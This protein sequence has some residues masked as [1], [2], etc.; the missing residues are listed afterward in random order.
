MVDFAAFENFKL[1]RDE[2]NALVVLQ[3]MK[4]DFILKRSSKDK[5]VKMEMT[6]WMGDWISLLYEAK[7]TTFKTPP[8]S[9]MQSEAIKMIENLPLLKMHI[10]VME[11]FLFEP[12]FPIGK[13]VFEGLGRTC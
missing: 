13:R 12:F 7:L 8:I 6:E 9:E 5:A 11:A 10:L 4:T 2:Y 3:V 1:S